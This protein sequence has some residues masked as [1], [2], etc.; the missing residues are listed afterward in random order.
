MESDGRLARGRLAKLEQKGL[1]SRL[2]RRIG[3]VRAGSSGQVWRLTAPGSRLAGYLTGEQLARG[4]EPFEPSEAF[5]RHTLACG[6]VFVQLSE[7]ARAGEIELLAFEAEPTCW[8]SFVG[9]YGEA[10]WLK[11]DEFVRIGVGDFEERAFVEV[12]LGTHGRA[13]VRRK[14]GVYGAF[15]LSGQDDASSRALWLVPDETRRRW[16]GELVRELPAEV[17][18]AHQVVCFDDLT[19]ALLRESTATKGGKA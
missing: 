9:E 14:L 15:Q 13:A 17:A 11:P 8:R 3:G 1:V 6:E 7:A 12:D 19:R 4:R 16:L 5:V 2:A 10:S 18:A